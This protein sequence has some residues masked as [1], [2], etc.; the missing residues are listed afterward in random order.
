L[1]SGTACE[2]VGAQLGML[3]TLHA[4]ARQ[5]GAARGNLPPASRFFESSGLLVARSGWGCKDS[6][7]FVTAEPREKKAGHSH[8]DFGAFQL[9]G[10]GVPLFLDAATWGYRID[11][12]VPAERGY[13]Y[14]AF[15][16]NMLTVEGY[17][18]KETFQSMGNVRGWWG[19]WN[20]PAVTVERVDLDGPRGEMVL[21]HRAYPG[22]QVMRRYSFDLA[23]RWLVFEDT[24][25]AEEVARCVFRQWLHAGFGAQLRLTGQDALRVTLN[26][27]HALCRWTASEPLELVVER[28]PEVERA[29]RVFQFGR[30]WRAYA[31]RGT[32][33]REFRIGCR[34]DWENQD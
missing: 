25:V 7:L 23:A 31:E 32:R 33:S 2:A 15:S 20:H 27:V 26:G 9:W 30:P 6:L 12:I 4:P 3:T 19:D 34:I 8:D 21:S 18:P 1:A 17:R 16:H 24:V 29:A 22:L 13:Y 5:G 11:Q 14:S 28:S 10:N